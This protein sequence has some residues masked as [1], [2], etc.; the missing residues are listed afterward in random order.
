MGK[1]IPC[2]RKVST[3]EKAKSISEKI[4]CK[5]T[6][7]QRQRKSIWTDQG[8]CSTRK[9]DYGRSTQRQHWGIHFHLKMLIKLKK[10][11]SSNLIL[12]GILTS[13]L[14]EWVY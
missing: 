13:N 14:H 11:I 10:D 3:A 8:I 6:T 5:R 9:Y 12:Q 2:R 1:V 7:A 4:D